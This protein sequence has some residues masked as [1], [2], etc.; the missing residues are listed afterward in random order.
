MYVGLANLS[1]ITSKLPSIAMYEH[2]RIYLFRSFVGEEVGSDS[3]ST[4]SSHASSMASVSS[5]AHEGSTSPTPASPSYPETKV[6]PIPFDLKDKYKTLQH[7]NKD[8]VPKRKWAFGRR[9]SQSRPETT[10]DISS[11]SLQK[12][13]IGDSSSPCLINRQRPSAMRGRRKSKEVTQA[14]IPECSYSFVIS[15]VK[16]IFRGSSRMDVPC[17]GKQYKIYTVCVC[18]CVKL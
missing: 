8:K 14:T 13:A 5:G 12:S 4:C 10:L 17:R 18:I 16:V 9:K 6:H 3:E 15:S 7:R 1:S 11:P 2:L